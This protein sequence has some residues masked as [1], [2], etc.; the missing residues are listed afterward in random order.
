MSA[1]P[2]V[3]RNSVDR[4]LFAWAAVVVL[5]VAV[6]GF[7]RTYYLKVAF[8]T[9]ALSALV[10]LHAALMTLWIA[11]FVVQT[12]FIA[13]QRI[14]LHRRAGM[15]GV[16][17]IVSIVAV[18]IPT[19]IASARHG[20]TVPGM[21]PLMFLVL[22]LGTAIVFALFASAAVLYRRRSDIHK[23]LMLLATL[24][25]LTP[26]IARVP[27]DAF[28]AVGPLLFLGLTDAIVLAF[29][30]Y[31]T[32]RNRRLHPAFGWGTLLLF[33]SQP[34]RMLLAHTAAWNEFAIWLTG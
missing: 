19:A 34:L 26:A 33:A 21:S 12:R 30:I 32:V 10:H 13:A 4:R 25:I 23:R 6:G 22:P 16:V 31:D 9:P 17:L 29:V 11:L 27:W 28:R 8:A 2:A 5:L 1:T 7:A 18:G 15:F 14:D 24:S 20:I 3:V